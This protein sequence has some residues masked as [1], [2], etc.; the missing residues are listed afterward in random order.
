MDEAGLVY[1][2]YALF[3]PV[4]FSHVICKRGTQGRLNIGREW[5]HAN[6]ATL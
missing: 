6:R 2:A 5:V 1:V 4:G 3:G